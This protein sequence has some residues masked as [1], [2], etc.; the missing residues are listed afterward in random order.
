LDQKKKP[1]LP[2]LAGK[3][4]PVFVDPRSQEVAVAWGMDDAKALFNFKATC[5]E[6][7]WTTYEVGLRNFFGF[8]RQVGLKSPREV[9]TTHITSYIEFLKTAGLAKRTINLYLSSAA[10]FFDFM[11]QPMDTKG[12]QLI[13][14]NPFHSVKKARPKVQAYEKE[15]HLREL[16]MDEYRKILAT[17]DRATV[18]GKRDHAI[19][20]LI[21]WTT[22]RRKEIVNLRVRDIGKDEKGVPYAKFLQKGAK[23]ITLDLTP[24]LMAEIEEYWKESGRTIAPD[25]PCFT[26]TT[27]AGKYLLKAR[28]LTQ[29]VGEGPMAASSLDQMIKKRAAQA[30]IDAE[31]VH[32]HIHGIR[33]LAAKFLRE[34][35]VDI[36]AIKERLGHGSLDT[37]DIYLGAME[38]VKAGNW[39]RLQQLELGGF[40]AGE[41]P[42]PK[43]KAG[44]EAK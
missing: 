27:D 7:T 6:S 19:I 42:G 41:A 29:R 31:Q 4:T 11:M 30:G 38:R 44:K 33:H 3:T 2:A 20:R 14:S 18:L 23:F 13:Q 10:S 37:T 5:R 26:A 28:G 21:F 16:T 8:C 22:R 43:K 12:T 15:T 40:D 24:P 1:M 35:G 36:K 25:S 9:E 34:S 32:A 39:Q 17:C